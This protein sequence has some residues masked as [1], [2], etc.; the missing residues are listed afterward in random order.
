MFAAARRVFNVSDHNPVERF[1]D[2]CDSL[3]HPESYLPGETPTPEHTAVIDPPQEPLAQRRTQVD[4]VNSQ[5]QQRT[6]VATRSR[7]RWD[8]QRL[9]DAEEVDASDEDAS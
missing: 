9:R 1:A 2:L 7:T 6:S 3:R 4:A 8:D 5:I